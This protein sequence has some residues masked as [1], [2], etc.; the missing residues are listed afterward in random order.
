[1]KISV[2]VPV[3]KVEPYLRRCVDSILR[4][5]FSD[6]ELILVDD[7]SPDRSGII[8]DEFAKS[9]SRVK[10]IHQKNR[11]L[12]AA[13]NSGID[14]VMVNSDSKFITFVDS[15]DW[16][17]PNYLLELIH[18]QSLGADVSCVGYVNVSGEDV[19][20]SQYPDEGWKLL[21]PEEYW[22]GNDTC[23]QSTAWGKLYRKD[24]FGEIRYPV[25]R[26][27]E[28]AFTTHLLVFQSKNVAVREAPLY[29]YFTGSQ[30]IMRSDWS[31]RK[32]DAVDAFLSQR[33]FFQK[34]EYLRSANLA[35]RK[36]LAV[37]AE[38][39]PHLEKIDKA[40]A[41]EYRALIDCAMV[42]G[43]LPFWDN[44]IVYRNMHV[45]FFAVRWFVGMIGNALTK[46]RRSWLAREALPIAKLLLCKFSSK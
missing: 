3:Y 43:E 46:G 45:R 5:T 38:S 13:R 7:G 15:D 1:M 41:D 27:M 19:R 12:S 10:V 31:V 6:F 21:S 29:D 28:D 36:A 2:I 22:I 39:I 25:G 23:A 37:M 32:L 14:F 26:L 40:K 33:D 34:N 16:V 24:L 4:Q 35:W 8:C 11:G 9:D 42:N 17:E 30:S 44:R 18:G 20:Y